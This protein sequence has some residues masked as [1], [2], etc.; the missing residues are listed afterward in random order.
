[1]RQLAQLPEHVYDAGIA[2][3]NEDRFGNKNDLDELASKQAREFDDEI[4]RCVEHLGG[5]VSV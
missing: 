2:H 1:M 5:G 4:D 3:P